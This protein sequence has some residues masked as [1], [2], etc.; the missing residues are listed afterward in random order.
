MNKTVLVSF[1]ERNKVLLISNSTNE[2]EVACLKEQF[3]RTF[4]E[5]ISEGQFITFQRFDSTWDSF[6]DLEESDSVED[7]DKLKVVITEVRADSTNTSSRD[8]VNSR[9]EVNT[10][11]S[12]NCLTPVEDLVSSLLQNNV[13]SA[14][15][16]PFEKILGTYGFN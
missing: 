7:R 15:L 10:E 8:P 4:N 16:K 14:C 13:E 2:K 1:K 12:E 9:D 11:V 3:C 5:T 6:V